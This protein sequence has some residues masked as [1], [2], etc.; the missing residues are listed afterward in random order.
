VRR[1]SETSAPTAASVTTKKS[2]RRTAGGAAAS[3]PK[4][5]PVLRTWVSAKK[6]SRSMVSCS[7][8]A[9]PTIPLLA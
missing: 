4:A 1:T 8:M 2:G 9:R 5:A 3:A 6:G 7:T